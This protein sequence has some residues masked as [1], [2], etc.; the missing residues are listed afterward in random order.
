MTTINELL[1]KHEDL[2]DINNFDTVSNFLFHLSSPTF[3]PSLYLDQLNEA[4]EIHEIIKDGIEKQQEGNIF[5]KLRKGFHDAFPENEPEH[6]TKEKAKNAQK[7]F[8]EFAKTRG[9]HSETYK[10]SFL[11]KNTKTKLSSGVGFSTIGLSLAPHNTSGYKFDVCPKATAECKANCLGLV[12][13][14]NKQYPET[15]FRGKLLSHQFLFEHPEESARLMS[16]EISENEKKCEKEGMKSG[17]RLNVTSDLP[18]EHLMPKKFFEKHKKTQFY[19]YTKIPGRISKNKPENY[20]LSLSHTGTDHDESN[21]KQALETLKN[22][23]VVSL[24][25][26][27]GKKIPHPTHVEDVNTGKR[28]RLVNGD[29]DDNVFD[30]GDGVVSGLKLKGVGNEK[31]GKF[32]NE[33]GADG[34]IRL[35]KKIHVKNI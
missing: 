22:G 21:D 26:Q 28:Y 16:H 9:G 14:G 17:V 1:E 24:V 25:Y 20:F 19:D 13:G 10:G 18:W 2:N 33:V 35:G 23:G 31:A 4:R 12:A 11:G 34:I 15:S 6:V 29:D 5:Q 30:R 7:L 8:H 32:A 3:T 27:R